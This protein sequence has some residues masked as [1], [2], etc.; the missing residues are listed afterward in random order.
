MSDANEIKKAAEPFRFCTRL[1]LFELTGIRAASIGDLLTHLKNVSGSCIYYHTHRFLQIHQNFSPEPPNDF[2]YWISEHLGD[3]ELAE[4]LASIDTVRFTSIRLLRESIISEIEKY[5]VEKPE[6]YAVKVKKGNEFNFI[7]ALSFVIPTDYAVSTISEFANV[8]EKVSVD[9]I[10]FHIFEAKLRLEK[11]ANDFSNW[12]ENSLGET[13]L[14]AK[15]AH[16]DPYTYTME[17]LRKEIM[18]ILRR[19]VK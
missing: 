14:A 10:Y 9:S 8:L 19:A 12:L 11:T 3:D 5:L 1:H 13:K 15:I 6:T 17:D 4:R 2:A 16:L 18:K 7:Q